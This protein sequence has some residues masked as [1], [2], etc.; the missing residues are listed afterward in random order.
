MH[1]WVEIN[2]SNLLDNLKAF[3]SL[4]GSSKVMPVIK[5]NAYGHGLSEVAELLKPSLKKDSWVGVNS[6]FEAKTLRSLGIDCEIL[7]LGPT[8]K[9]DLVQHE[10]LNVKFVLGHHDLLDAW[11][12]MDSPPVCHLKI[13][14]G[15]SRQGF[16]LEELELAGKKIKDSAHGFSKVEALATHFSNVEDVLEHDYANSQLEEFKKGHEI[17]KSFGFSGFTHAAS[18]ASTLLLPESRFDA[19]RV[20]ISL[21]GFWPSKATRLSYLKGHEKLCSLKRVL[22]WKTKIAQVK[23]VK[24]GRFI[25]YGCTYRAPSDI[26]IAV[27]PVGY[28]EGYPRLA[29]DRQSY[30]LIDGNRCNVVGRICMNMMMIDVSHL[31]APKAGMEVTLIGKDGTEELDAETVGEWADTI[32]Y[33]LVTRINSE[34]ERRVV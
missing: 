25:G 31:S 27:I 18:S 32:H 16:N 6:L 3:E 21:Y 9:E 7:V 23:N 8:F 24:K 4:A 29:S 20:G 10:N 34:L 1:S 2:K 28:Y 22:S 12:K 26:V 17:L 14:T 13:D 19:V 11:L 30:V 33:E 5:S 15:M